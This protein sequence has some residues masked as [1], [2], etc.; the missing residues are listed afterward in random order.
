M[1]WKIPLFKICWDE[2][3][4]KRIDDSVRSGMNW[5]VGENVESFEKG[6]SEYIGSKYCL[7][8]NSGTSALHAVLMA[9]GIGP[10]DEVIVPSFTFIATANSPLFVGAR[11]VFADIEE[12]TYGLNPDDVA[13]KITAKTKAIMPIHYG[14]C[15]CK[16]RELKDLAEDKGVLLIEDAAESFGAGI[17]GQKAGTFGD[18]AMLSFC[19]NKVITTG[20]G[21]AIVTD[22]KDVY[23]SLKLIRSH[24]RLETSD[25]FSSTDYMDYVSLGYNFR[26][27][28]I[29]AS[30]GISQLGKAD[31]IIA[32][33][34]EKAGYL[35]DK[36]QRM[37]EISLPK[38]PQDYFHVYQMYTI[39]L[40]R[41]DEM[42][43]HLAERG[44]MSKV[45]FYPVHTTSFYRRKL[46]YEVKLPVTES[47]STSILTLPMH[48]AIS[49]GELDGVAEGIEDFYK[50]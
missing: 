20:E 30:L 3:D 9:H 21:G 7:T 4:L 14:G 48:P 11:P 13:E 10:G 44:I 25:Y 32:L 35:T 38:P 12:E 31:R 28:N 6:L 26:M 34:R 33:R 45:Y 46:G 47:V 29:V 39:R 37:K 15:P 27:S 16:I 1:S 40:K 43:E 2:D 18:S 36:L 19:Q 50:R 49:R 5:A 22:S 23:E 24:G 41:R 8:F 42:I 17:K